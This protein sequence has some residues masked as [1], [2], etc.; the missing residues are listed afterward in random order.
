MLA[1]LCA[2]DIAHAQ[3]KSDFSYVFSVF[4]THAHDV[5]HY[6]QGLAIHEKKL[7]EG[8]GLHGRSALYVSE[9]RTG[10]TLHSR[11]NAQ[12]IFGEGVAVLNNNVYQLSWRNRIGF[13]YD[14][15]LKPLRRFEYD[16]EGWGLASD[17]TQLIMSD[18]SAR[19]V[20]RDARTLQVT[21]SVT[22]RDGAKPIAWLNELEYAQ[23][24][25]WANVWQSDRIAVILPDSGRVEGWLDLSPLK[26]SFAKPQGWNEV[27]HV[28]NGIAYDDSSGRY[29]VTGKC[30]PVM[31][32]IT[33]S[34]DSGN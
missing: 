18:G 28:L 17:G 29:F 24:R 27:E 33:I 20:W 32:E 16:T 2:C 6:T 23:G 21:R 30:W 1:M 12:E 34:R 15:A 19:L 7:Y 13:I 5:S 14:L 4:Q 3:Q 31:F 8:T 26:K 25:I 22:V 9:L 11:K 10:K